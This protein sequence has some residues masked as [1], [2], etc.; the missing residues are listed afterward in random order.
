VEL[1]Y[2]VLGKSE[3]GA[4]VQCEIREGRMQRA[5]TLKCMDCGSNASDYDHRDYNRPLDVQPVCRSCNLRRGPAIPKSGW[6]ERAL[7]Y[8]VN[9]YR[10]RSRAHRV[11][12]L[13]GMRHGVLAEMPPRLDLGHWQQIG[14]VLRMQS[15][16]T[17]KPAALA[18]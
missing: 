3:A 11:F 4:A 16:A 10:T 18:G 14:E 12:D 9:P 5:H 15:D 13:L 6:L 8:H 2:D 1:N 7:K 17:P